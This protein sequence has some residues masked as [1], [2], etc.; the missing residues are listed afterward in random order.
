MLYLAFGF[1]DDPRALWLL[2]PAYGLF[3]AATEGA[4]KALVADLVEPELRGRAFGWFY[5]MSGLPLLPASLL[6]GWAM[7]WHSAL[8]FGFSAGCALAAAALLAWH[9]RPL[10]RVQSPKT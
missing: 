9:V 2:F 1:I 6:F 8:A 7:Q 10:V 5:L 4:E 3:M